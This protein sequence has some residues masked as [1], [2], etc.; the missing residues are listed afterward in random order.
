MVHD[1][2]GLVELTPATEAVLDAIRDSGG[3]PLLV[4][5]CVRDA[6]LGDVHPKDID[7]EVHGLHDVEQ[8]TSELSKHGR[9][10][11]VG[12]SFGVLKVTVDGEDFDVSLP[13]TESKSG[14]GHRG[15]E[16]TVDPTADE[17]T[18]SGRRDFTVNALMYDPSSG[19]LIDCW[20]GVDDLQACILR[21]TTPA[22]ADDP[23][24]VLRGV[25]F[26]SRYG[27]RFADDTAELCRTLS[28]EYATLPKERV[29]GE[30]SKALTRGSHISTMLHQ[31]DRTGWIEHYPQ[32]AVLRTVEQDPRHHP[33]GVVFEHTGQAGDAAARVA[34]RD[35]L[36]GEDRFVIVTAAMLHDTGKA[37]H[38]QHHH[39]PDGTVRITSHG[40]AEAGVEPTRAFLQSIGA[41]GHVQARVVPLVAEHMCSVSIKGEPT[42]R[43]VS[44]LAR[45]LSPASVQEWARV[46]E[47]DRSGRG[48]ASGY[49]GHAHRWVAMAD[50]LGVAQEPAKRLLT[51]DV[52]IAAG[53][54]PGPQFRE[55][56]DRSIEAQDAGEFTDADG[57]RAW[58]ERA[59]A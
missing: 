9:V 48:T 26:V 24:R 57:A 4:G 28:G 22:F 27:W 17:I 14:Q 47:A 45:R 13:R 11:A 32:L 21:H 52:L 46:V 53:M 41:P 54:R 44:S 30:W 18:A 40:H 51:G 19:E 23:L 50:Q 43:A 33:E 2:P 55:I 38:T 3:R 37:T 8:L 36:T 39:E 12:A 42:R 31:L 35:G 10:D 20:G 7:I 59:Y 25:Q 6:L 15:F 29:W 16:I 34:D 56:L 5:G 58:F 1:R 49:D